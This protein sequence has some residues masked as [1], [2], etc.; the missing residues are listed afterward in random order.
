MGKSIQAKARNPEDYERANYIKVLQGYEA[1]VSQLKDRKAMIFPR[2]I[3]AFAQ[4][5][6]R[7]RSVASG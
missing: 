3:A 5:R 2:L 6:G 7:C 1:R 4:L